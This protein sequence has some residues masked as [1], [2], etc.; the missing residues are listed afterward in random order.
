MSGPSGTNEA[1]GEL[2]GASSPC[3]HHS[4]SKLNPLNLT[5]P[6]YPLPPPRPCAEVQNPVSCLPGNK[7]GEEYP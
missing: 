4:S 6:T 1:S 7:A 5:P 2:R 3:C